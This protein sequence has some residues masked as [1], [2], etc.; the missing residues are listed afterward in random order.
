MTGCV[1]LSLLRGSLLV[2]PAFYFGNIQTSGNL[3][4]RKMNLFIRL[5]EICP[6]P[7]A[8]PLATLLPVSFALH[9]LLL[10]R[11]RMTRWIIGC[12]S[13]P[14]LGGR[15]EPY[16]ATKPVPHLTILALISYSPCVSGCC[17]W[18]FLALLFQFRIHL[19]VMLHLLRSMGFCFVL[20]FKSR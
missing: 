1:V 5:T 20:F 19:N 15:T 2:P 3:K 12:T 14:F 10:S 6:S 11:F 4:G 18:W 17:L 9:V 8:S 16:I 13:V 7:C